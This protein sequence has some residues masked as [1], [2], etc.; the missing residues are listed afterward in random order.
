MDK[1]YLRLEDGTELE[2]GSFGAPVFTI[3][4]NNLKVKSWD[5]Y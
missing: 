4:F 5:E 2:G 1:G 3:K